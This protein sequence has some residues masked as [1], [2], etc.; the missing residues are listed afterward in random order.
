M[1]FLSVIHPRP[2]RYSSSLT[3]GKRAVAYRQRELDVRQ[4]AINNLYP[5]LVL[6]S[7]LY[8]TKNT[9]LLAPGKRLTAEMLNALRKAGH[10]CAFL[11]DARGG[12]RAQ[13]ENQRDIVALRAEAEGQAKELLREFDRLLSVQELEP[14]P[15]G[16]PARDGMRRD[17][18]AERKAEE[19]AAAQKLLYAA[20]S[21]L[22]DIAKGWVHNDQ[23]GTAALNTVSGLATALGEDPSLLA[24]MAQ[25]KRTDGYLFPHAVNVSMLSMQIGAALDYDRKQVTEIGM[26]SLLQDLG[27]SLVPDELRRAP[28]TLDAIEMLDVQKHTYRSA[29][30]LGHFRGLPVIPTFVAMQCHERND[31]TGYP[32]RRQRGLIHRFARIV[33]VADVYDSLISTRPWR[34]ALHPYDAIEKLLRWS[35]SGR[36]DA[37]AVRGLL[38]SLSLY[39]IGTFVRLSNG[40]VARVVHAGGAAF[41]RPTVAVVSEANSTRL[42]EPAYIDLAK[43]TDLSVVEVVRDESELQP[44]HGF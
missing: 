4:I 41:T 13:K 32:R 24:L 42:M 15:Q 3:C 21:T 9:L 34:D 20:D 10:D 11:G 35:H 23:V 14:K 36:Y 1:D 37:D 33:A 39:P 26:A 18:R 7:P 40:E 19:F 6:S 38:H 2:K 27:M 44:F 31:G 17:R 25:G 16:K 30:L 28:R 5:G 22:E 12:T 43:R 8:D 29:Y